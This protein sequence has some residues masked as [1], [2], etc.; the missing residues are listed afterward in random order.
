[1][2]SGIAS[3]L[4]GS[5]DDEVLNA[6]QMD[7]TEADDEWVLVDVTNVRRS[8]RISRDSSPAKENLG[9]RG[10]APSDAIPIPGE[11]SWFMTPPPC[12]NAGSPGHIATSPMENLLIEH[13]SMSVYHS[14][15]SREVHCRVGNSRQPIRK[16][17]LRVRT[18]HQ[19]KRAAA[20]ADRLGIE[21][22]HS[23]AL[24]HARKIENKQFSKSLS[25]SK[26]ERANKAYHQES[27]GKRHY[28]QNK[29][30]KHTKAIY[31]QC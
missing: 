12:F 14:S 29:Q 24:V 9:D 5:N 27:T 3:F 7:L 18:V 21:Q 25:R 30:G 26:V 17:K 19:P 15:T 8:P 4:F 10:A 22:S 23:A 13:P 2:L 16:H 11:E 20:I 28:R 31:K 6:Q 1:M